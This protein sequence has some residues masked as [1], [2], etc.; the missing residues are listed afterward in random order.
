[1]GCSF[2]I[3]Y[4]IS[5]QAR[6]CYGFTEALRGLPTEGLAE[7]GRERGGLVNWFRDF[8]AENRY[9]TLL[10]NLLALTAA[11]FPSVDAHIS[12][13]CSAERSQIIHKPKKRQ[14]KIN[15]KSPFNHSEEKIS[16]FTLR[17]V[18]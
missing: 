16:L 10:S 8:S 1:M 9:E 13:F 15:K 6:I 4:L 2:T 18:P 14:Q 17:K 12:T 7:V 5:Q 11:I 3:I